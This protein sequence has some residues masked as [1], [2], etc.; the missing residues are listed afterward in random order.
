MKRFRVGVIGVGFIGAVHIEQL[1]AFR[2]GSR[3]L[4][5][6]AAAALLNHAGYLLLSDVTLLAFPM[7]AR[8]KIREWERRRAKL[9]ALKGE[10]SINGKP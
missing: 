9:I 5:T 3:E 8:K 10:R 2:T 6:H 7:A 1:R 4:P